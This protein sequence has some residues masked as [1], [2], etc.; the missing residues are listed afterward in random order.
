MHPFIGPVFH[1]LPA[2]GGKTFLYM[3]TITLAITT[4]ERYAY[5][6]ESFINVLDD[7]RISEIIIVSDSD[8]KLLFDKIKL[9]CDP[10]PKIKLYYNIKNQDCY[11]N[12][13]IAVSYSSSPWLI[14]FDSDNVLT[15]D[16]L[17]KLFEIEKWEEDTVYQPSFAQPNFDFRA[18]SG[19]TIT[20]TNVGGYMDKPMFSTALNAFNY[21]L[22]RDF[23]LQVWDGKIDPVTADSIFHNYNHLRKGGKIKFVDGLFYFHRVHDQSHY[24]TNNKRT[25]NTYQIIEN[26][27]KAMR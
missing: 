24:K 20:N 6:V 9:F 10:Y 14:L 16:Y 25:G 5:L 1:Q 18:Y 12:K 22:N 3:R 2:T 23:F 26:R 7:P 21:F 11:R 8:E 13:Q 27:L 4:Y 15:K 17:D 19:L